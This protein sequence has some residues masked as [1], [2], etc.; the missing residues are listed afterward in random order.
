MIENYPGFDLVIKN[1]DDF[2]VATEEE[3]GNLHLKFYGATEETYLIHFLQTKSESKQ[4]D[5]TREPGRNDVN[6]KIVY[7][8]FD[9]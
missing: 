1:I 2:Y 8:M 7:D 4:F 3:Y 6:R 9:S 5:S